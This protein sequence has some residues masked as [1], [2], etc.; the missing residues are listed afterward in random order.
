MDKLLGQRKKVDCVEG[1]NGNRKLTYRTKNWI[2]SIR[3]TA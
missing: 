1:L 2:Y 3:N